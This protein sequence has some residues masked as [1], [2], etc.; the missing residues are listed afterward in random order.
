MRMLDLQF[1]VPD[2][3][4]TVAKVDNC[5]P[6]RPGQPVAGLCPPRCPA[7][8]LPAPPPFFVPQGPLASR[9]PPRTPR[10]RRLCPPQRSLGRGRGHSR[11][12][13]FP[14][15]VGVI[16]AC[17]R[18]ASAAPPHPSRRAGASPRL[19]VEFSGS[20][21]CAWLWESRGGGGRFCG[22]GSLSIRIADTH[23]LRGPCVCAQL[24]VGPSIWL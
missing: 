23:E 24:R 12:R 6:Y 7:A 8:T 9:S 11:R 21:R 14:C 10:V 22:L 4:P 15:R 2:A 13:L 16:H 1:T 19:P 20:A 5:L 18:C 17:A 3:S